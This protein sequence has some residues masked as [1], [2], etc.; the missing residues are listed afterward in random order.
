[1]KIRPVASRWRAIKTHINLTLETFLPADR[2][3][4][5]IFQEIHEAATPFLEAIANKTRLLIDGDLKNESDLLFPK[6][7]VSKFARS[8]RHHCEV[9]EDFAHSKGAVQNCFAW[10]PTDFALFGPDVSIV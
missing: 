10:D 3:K 2:Q 4:E 1:M 8:S 9:K 6:R 7:L 5:K